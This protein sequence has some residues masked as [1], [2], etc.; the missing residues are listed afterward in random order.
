MK[1][2]IAKCIKNRY[3][4]AYSIEEVVT[5]LNKL[6]Q[7]IEQVPEGL[8]LNYTA[9]VQ[10]H[11]DDLEENETYWSV[12]LKKEDEKDEYA[13]SFVPFNELF[14]YPV[15]GYQEDAEIIGDIIWDLTFDGWTPEQQNQR[16]RDFE[17]R[18]E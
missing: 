7:T 16:I 9:L 6:E 12:S 10:H 13:V 17:D 18:M 1:T 3:M 11:K 5:L 15:K 14:R 8:D 4:T 2:E